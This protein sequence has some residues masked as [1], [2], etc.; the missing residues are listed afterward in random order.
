[1]YGPKIGFISW[2]IPSEG[3]FKCQYFDETT[4]Y[5]QNLP[6][7]DDVDGDESIYCRLFKEKVVIEVKE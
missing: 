4:M 3:C 6:R 2:D 7:L 1:M 5:C